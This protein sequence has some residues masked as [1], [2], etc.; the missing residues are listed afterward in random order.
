M[1]GCPSPPLR[2][3]P[4]PGAGGVAAQ[5]A[6]EVRVCAFG[7]RGAA[8][9]LRHQRRA[10]RPSALRRARHLRVAA[11]RR[12]S[13]GHEPRDRVCKGAAAVPAAAAWPPEGG[14]AVRPPAPRVDARL[15]SVE[16]GRLVDRPVVESQLRRDETRRRPA[17]VRRLLRL[18]RLLPRRLPAAAVSAGRPPAGRPPA[19]CRAARPARKRAEGLRRRGQPAPPPPAARA[20][21]RAPPRSRAAAPALLAPLALRRRGRRAGR[22][23]SARRRRRRRASPCG[24]SSASR[25]SPGTPAAA[26]GAG[27]PPAGPHPPR[28]SPR[29]PRWPCGTRPSATA[30]GCSAVTRT[31]WRASRESP[32][33]WTRA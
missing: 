19:G 10:A 13:A 2:S 29:G 33:L 12:D 16:R 30:S 18:L 7:P 4:H 32:S 3:P 24:A 23:P 26:A 11:A 9:L 14:S 21:R 5:A 31:A 17:R 20:S 15:A 27:R 28:R 8:I 6:A 25:R 22:S 1:L